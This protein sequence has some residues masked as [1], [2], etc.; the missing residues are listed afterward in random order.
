MCT[1]L[2]GSKTTTAY[3]GVIE[4]IEQLC[5]WFCAFTMFSVTFCAFSILIF[6]A[7]N[8]S[9]LARERN[10]SFWFFR[11]CMYLSIV[12]SKWWQ[13]ISS[14][15]DDLRQEAATFNDNVKTSNGKDPEGLMQRFCH[16]AQLHSD[17]KEYELWKLPE[18]KLR[19]KPSTHFRLVNNFNEV[20]RFSIFAVISWAIFGECS[21][22]LALRSQ[23]VE[24]FFSSFNFF[25]RVNFNF[26]PLL[27][28]RTIDQNWLRSLFLQLWRFGHSWLFCR[29]VSPAN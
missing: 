22:L 8:Y 27:H 16:I 5:K 21:I 17:A 12:G 24:Y 19:A 26:V 28:R 13:F 18:K 9:S 2:I 1:I 20:H 10:H 14:A 3:N 25:Y 6:T 15:S 7:V 29:N 4:K 23:L 11:L